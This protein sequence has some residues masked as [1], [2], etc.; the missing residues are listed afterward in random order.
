MRSLFVLAL[1]LALPLAAG[2]PAGGENAARPPKDS[3]V[4]VRVE[5]EVRG[6][7]RRAGKGFTVSSRLRVYELY[8]QAKEL[9]Q[10]SAGRPADVFDLDFSRAGELEELAE[11]LKGREVVVTGMGELRM[12]DQS[13]PPGGGDSFGHSAPPPGPTWSLQRIVLVKHL[14]AAEG[15]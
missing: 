8:D 3:C 4:K 7:L 14:K 2:A 12:V 1:G 6:V 10:S 11:A 15:K 13:R 9:P 5:V